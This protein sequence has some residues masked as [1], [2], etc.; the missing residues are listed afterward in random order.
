MAPIT[1]QIEDPNSYGYYHALDA[2]VKAGATLTITP[3]LVN[4]HFTVVIDNRNGFILNAG[5]VIN[6]TLNQTNGEVL[7][8]EVT[9]SG[10]PVKE[11]GIY[12]NSGTIPGVDPEAPPRI[13]RVV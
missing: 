2:L 13:I 1:L 12:E 8:G 4:V 6:L 10:N 11:Y 9:L 5:K 7:I 3:A